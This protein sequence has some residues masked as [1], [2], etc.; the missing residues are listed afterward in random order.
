[1]W[2][3]TGASG[4]L[5]RRIVESALRRRPA[6][7]I[8]V[9]VRD[10]AKVQGLAE[11]GVRV[12]GADFE[13]ATALHAAFEGASQ[14]VLVSSNAR[15]IG[16]DSLA[17]HRRA[18]EVARAVGVKRILYTSH[19]AA[20]ATS[21]FPPMHDHAA[22]E[23]LLA[24][25]GVAW[26]ALRNGFYASSA[27]AMCADGIARGVLSFPEDGKVS[28]TSHDDLAEAAAAILE[29]DGEFEGPT[30][31]LVASEALDLADI[32]ALATEVRGRDVRREVVTDEVLRERMAGIHPARVA[33]TLGLF[34]A[35][36]DGEFVSS[37]RTL[38]TLLGRRPQPLRSL[39]SAEPSSR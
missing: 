23:A 31:P 38:E 11:R 33:I 8:G 35:S 13:D 28:W 12:R 6:S 36:R 5:G 34:R 14:L 20:S 30:P 39:M 21:A 18:I 15:A 32:A 22:T 3:I 37:D 25:S 16:G 19:M 27:L 17:Q 29:R 4:E 7:E 1:M 24:Q 9:S 26:T 2:V 10:V